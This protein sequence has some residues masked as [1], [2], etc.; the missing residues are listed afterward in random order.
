[1]WTSVSRCSRRT[2]DVLEYDDATRRPSSRPSN[3]GPQR[4][5][6]AGM[7]ALDYGDNLDVLGGRGRPG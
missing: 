2:S 6:A 1:M 7:N 5:R 3:F 4:A